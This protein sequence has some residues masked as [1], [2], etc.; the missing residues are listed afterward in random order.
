[1]P[2]IAIVLL[3]RCGEGFLLEPA[4]SLFIGRAG[5]RTG[6]VARRAFLETEFSILR[7]VSVMSRVFVQTEMIVSSLRR[8]NVSESLP[9]LDTSGL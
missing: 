2:A 1:M 4:A 5:R 7:T 9:L 8:M 6:L 3:G